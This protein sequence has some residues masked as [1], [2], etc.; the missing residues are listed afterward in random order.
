MT[1]MGSISMMNFKSDQVLVGR[2]H[3]LCAANALESLSG[4]RALESKGSVA[5]FYGLHISFGSVPS[6]TKDSRTER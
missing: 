1:G 3:E 4:R 5:G 6:C 2:S